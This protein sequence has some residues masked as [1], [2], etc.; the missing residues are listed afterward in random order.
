MQVKQ[1]QQESAK[2]NQIEGRKK[3]FK[4]KMQNNIVHR[5]HFHY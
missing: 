5:V 1:S 2:Q 4:E 3:T